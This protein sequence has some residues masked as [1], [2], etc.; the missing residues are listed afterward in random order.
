MD[1]GSGGRAWRVD[2]EKERL[3]V[4]SDELFYTPIDNICTEHKHDISA[5]NDCIFHSEGIVNFRESSVSF[6]CYDYDSPRADD[7][8]TVSDRRGLVS[9]TEGQWVNP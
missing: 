7:D 6:V 8:N 9:G 4:N 1:G 5:S 3:I 2:S